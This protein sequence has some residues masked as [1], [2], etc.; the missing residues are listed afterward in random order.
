MSTINIGLTILNKFLYYVVFFYLF[1]F[2]CMPGI[3]FKYRGLTIVITFTI[4][5]LL[6]KVLGIQLP[7]YAFTLRF[8]KDFSIVSNIMLEKIVGDIL[9]LVT[10][11][12]F[13]EGEQR[14]KKIVYI[15]PTFLFYLLMLRPANTLADFFNFS[16]GGS[17]TYSLSIRYILWIINEAVL[18]IIVLKWRSEGMTQ[19]EL[20][21]MDCLILIAID[22]LI[23]SSAPLLY[24]L[25][26][27]DNAIYKNI[28]L[29]NCSIIIVFE[30]IL[31]DFVLIRKYRHYKVGRQKMMNE[32]YKSQQ[33]Y[34]E[35]Y[36]ARQEQTR[37]FYHDFKN[38]LLIMQQ[39][40]NPIELREYVSE[41]IS[42]MSSISG[43]YFT[44]NQTF[45]YILNS[46]SELIIKNGIKLSLEGKLPSEFEL[47]PYS[48]C[49]LFGNALDNA[50]EATMQLK[51]EK[52][53][54][55][56]YLSELQGFVKVNIKNSFKGE[57]LTNENQ[58]MTSK[59][60]SDV[61]GYGMMN[62]KQEVIKYQGHLLW[63]ATPLNNEGV[64]EFSL[65]LIFP[66]SYHS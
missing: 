36:K 28:Q 41:L 60:D 20:S 27:G 16:V 44:G 50:I 13:Y 54:I 18:L 43:G 15:L 59:K 22:W 66:I 37:Q 53:F 29:Y 11:L 52:R 35:I 8:P 65:F 6:I 10:I 58:L 57:L 51:E 32:Y 25:C 1:G 17:S 38:H 2:I 40:Q 39:I 48:A 34:F 55:S 46:K 5:S 23:F 19:I 47:K 7:I 49:T 61:H 64:K 21:L 4:M 24:Y 63:E 12:A 42:K 31:I 45:D 30:I 3:K 14:L 26:K 9:F 56:M 33:E 62:M